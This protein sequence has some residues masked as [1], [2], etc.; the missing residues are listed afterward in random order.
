M[1][2]EVGATELLFEINVLEDTTELLDVLL[3]EEL[4]FFEEVGATELL[5]LV[6]VL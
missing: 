6:E 1:V 5:L 2:D 4:V 3:L